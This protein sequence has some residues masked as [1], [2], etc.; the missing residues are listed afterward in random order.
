VFGDLDMAKK[1]SIISLLSVLLA[2]APLIHMGSEGQVTKSFV[3]TP[4]VYGQEDVTRLLRKSGID[5]AVVSDV[6]RNASGTE[7]FV[8]LFDSFTNRFSVIKITTNGLVRL[9]A[10]GREAVPGPDG[11]FVAWGG[12]TGNAIHL[13]NDQLLQLPEFGLFS[14]DPGGKYFVVGEKPN[15]AWLGR[16]RSPQKRVVVADD[17]LPGSIFVSKGKIYIAGHSYIQNRPGQGEPFTTCLILKDEGED[18]KIVKRLHFDWASGVVEVD[19]F[20]DRLLLWDK[21]LVSHSVYS[22]DLATKQRHRV[23]RVKGFQFFLA[24]DVLK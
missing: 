4:F 18:F 21:A 14:I 12:E 22:Y 3:T 7:L 16:V 2:G 10:P 11:G 8:Y 15:K 6:R 19:P 20:A 13:Q 5:V 9:A 24:T 23:G 1:T 17:L